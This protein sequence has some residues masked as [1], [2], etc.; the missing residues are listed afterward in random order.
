MMLELAFALTVLGISLLGLSLGWHS[1]PPHEDPVDTLRRKNDAM[2]RR[3][4][5][6]QD[7]PHSFNYTDET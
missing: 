2:E 7:R 3:L 5:R 6:L 4:R 1:G